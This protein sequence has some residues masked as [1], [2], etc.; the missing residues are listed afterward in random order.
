MENQLN[1]RSA[2]LVSF[3]CFSTALPAAHAEPGDAFFGDNTPVV[4]QPV[5]EVSQLSA[6]GKKSQALALAEKELEKNEK[7]VQ[8]KFMRGV[9]LNDLNRK[10]E[11]KK[12][13]ETLIREYPEIA[14]P[15]NNLA[16]MY[17]ADGNLGRARELLEEALANNPKSLITLSNLGDIYLALARA[18]YRAAGA[19][20]PKNKGIQTR[21]KAIDAILQE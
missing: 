15:Y 14:E 9:L 21:L 16:V 10:D 7:N 2:V 8:L 17:A 13:F 4:Y 20:A 1:L 18:Q 5:K 3:I 19:L 12:V 6:A 11:A